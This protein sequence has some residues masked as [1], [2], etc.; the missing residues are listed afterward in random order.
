MV[1]CG[2]PVSQWT[3]FPVHSNVIFMLPDLKLSYYNTFIPHPERHIYLAYNALS[4]A[5]L[6][7]DWDSGLMLSK[8]NSMEIHYL[9][10]DLIE[11]LVQ[12]GMIIS[13]DVDEFDVVGKRANTSRKTMENSDT[14]FMVIS[15][16]NTCN[17]NCPYCYQGDKTPDSSDTKYLGKENLEAMKQLVSRSVLQ[18]K[19]QPI[20]NIRIEWFG[21]EPLIRKNTIEEFSDF[22]IALADEHEIQYQASIITNGTLLDERTYKMLERS[23]V[24]KIQITLDGDKSMHDSMRF[25]I[26]GKGTYEKILNNLNLMPRHKFQ[27]V[28]RING[29]KAVFSHLDQMFDDLE[30]RGI[31]PQRFDEIAFDWSPKFYNFD[32]Y[33]QNKDVY[34][35]SYQYQQSKEDFARLKLDRFNDWARRNGLRARKL[36]VA[37]PKFATFYCGTVES[38]NAM[39]VDDGG[40]IHKCYNTINNKSKR[41]QHVSDFDPYGPGTD[42]YKHFDKTKAADCRTCKALPICEESCNM[43]FVL[44][45]ESKICSPWKFFMEERMRAIYEQNFS[46]DEPQAAIVTKVKDV[47][48]C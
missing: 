35:T 24:K 39:G 20:R 19:A 11:S 7:L 41:T 31:W 32:G 1:R 33:N 44:N 2:T 45:S 40:Y 36:K 48:I 28:L 12:N 6:Q 37:Y 23:R 4:N 10:P 30:A 47:E 34:Y 46:E 18:P 27:L 38:P 42:T 14:M 43:R 26:S 9:D 29:D 3:F 15:P 5:M 16:T 17:M 21:G 25:Y 13:K 22:V 8:L